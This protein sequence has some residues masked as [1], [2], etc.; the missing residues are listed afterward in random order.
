MVLNILLLQQGITSLEDLAILLDRV[1]EPRAVEHIV[2]HGRSRACRERRADASHVGLL[3]RGAAARVVENMD[4]SLDVPTAT[5]TRNIPVK[6]LE[7]SGILENTILFFLSDNGA[8]KTGDNGHLRGFKGSLW[9]GGH[10]VP[11]IVKWPGRIEP[12]TESDALIGQVDLYATLAA[13]LEN[14]QQ[15]D[16]SVIVPEVLRPWMGGVETI[17]ATNE[18]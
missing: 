11:F 2:P 3:V 16:G 13:I 17:N 6:L 15:A 10:R 12:N 1:G 18:G 7:E 5:S 9:E 4:A 8:N 14:F